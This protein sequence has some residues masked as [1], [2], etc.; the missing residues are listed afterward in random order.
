MMIAG[1]DNAEG[2]SQQ[3][4]QSGSPTQAGSTKLDP[5]TGS[6]PGIR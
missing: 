5:M 4:D 6:T 2:S 1:F 3:N